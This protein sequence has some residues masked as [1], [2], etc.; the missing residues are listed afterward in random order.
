MCGAIPRFQETHNVFGIQT[1]G[2][3]YGFFV[4]EK[5]SARTG[6]RIYITLAVRT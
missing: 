1:V 6:F 2:L 3:P 4:R 5:A